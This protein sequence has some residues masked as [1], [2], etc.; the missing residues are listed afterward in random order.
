MQLHPDRDA[1]SYYVEQIRRLK[2][3]VLM[4]R[5]KP[6]YWFAR[7]AVALNVLVCLVGV[8]WFDAS[9]YCAWGQRAE[10]LSD[11]SSVGCGMGIRGA[12]AIDGHIR[13]VP[14]ILATEIRHGRT[15]A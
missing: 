12:V 2:E 3:Q 4:E 1:T 7:M 15:T 10:R 13:G 8:S 11:R 9:E 6:R 5:L 14:R